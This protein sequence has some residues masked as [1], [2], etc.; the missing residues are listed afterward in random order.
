MITRIVKMTFKPEEI[1][2]FLTVFEKQKQFIAGFDGCSHVEL[3]RD[4]TNPNI[5]FTYS[6]W[7]N[8][9]ALQRYR[10]S[11]FFKNIWS[12][13]KQKFADKPLAWSTTKVG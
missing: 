12:T 10:E 6:Y 3:L 4:N 5:F 11:N 2:D 1:Q 9:R 13:V 7:E 8:D